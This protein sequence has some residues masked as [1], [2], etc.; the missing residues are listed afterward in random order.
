[1]FK[2]LLILA[3]GIAIGYS[4]G[5]GDAQVNDKPIAERILDQ[6]GGKTRDAMGNDVDKK[7]GAIA[8]K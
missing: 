1:M 5:W 8:D 6:V 2:L 7:L 3:V 4:Y